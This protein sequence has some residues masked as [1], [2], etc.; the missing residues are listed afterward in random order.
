RAAN[1]GPVV[2]V[3]EPIA[4]ATYCLRVLGQQ[5]PPL[6]S[7]AVFDF[8]GGTLDVSVVRREFDG[9]RVLGV[10]GLDD[11]GGGDI[12]AALGGPPGQLI[13]LRH[14][15]ICQ[16]LSNPDSTAAYRDRRALW[17]EVRAAKEML[18]RAASA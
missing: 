4:A 13:N 6:Q 14:P 15:E 3:D 16:R 11:L 9:L 8:G 5:S 10:G 12:D 2:L 17:T 7:L 1:L 18:S